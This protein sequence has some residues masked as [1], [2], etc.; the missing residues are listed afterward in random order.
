MKEGFIVGTIYENIFD[1]ILLHKKIILFEY[2]YVPNNTSTLNINKILKIN[3][4]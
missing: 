3:K 4:L 2:K 1:K